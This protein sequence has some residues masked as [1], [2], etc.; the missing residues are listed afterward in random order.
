MNDSVG[1][2]ASWNLESM[3]IIKEF[4]FDAGLPTTILI[5]ACLLLWF[6]ILK[7]VMKFLFTF[8][9]LFLLLVCYKE[10]PFY[11][12]KP[13]LYFEKIDFNDIQK[14]QYRVSEIVPNCLHQGMPLVVLGGGLYQKDIPSTLSQL[15]VLGLTN[16]L[17]ISKKQENL[18]TSKTPLY[19][20]G[21]YTNPNVNQ[22]EAEAM[23]SF[24]KYLYRSNSPE[25][26]INTDNNSKNTYQNA[27]YLKEIFTK[28]HEDFKIALVTSDVH[29]L[30]AKKT[31]EKQG[32]QVCAVPVRTFD[33]KGAGIFSFNNAVTSVGL[34]NEYLGIMGYSYKG[35]ISI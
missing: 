6:C 21:G 4:V 2:V 15:R 32:F 19:F 25:L 5:L 9:S 13:L 27:A 31:F 35:W 30:R 34:L 20:T 3:T 29:M 26:K 8:A 24:F 16:L 7:K 17:E 14:T 23:K 1:N 33:K 11:L 10:T 22:S 28:N 18:I 12:S